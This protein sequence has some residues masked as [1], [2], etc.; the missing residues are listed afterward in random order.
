MAK[1]LPLNA[2]VALSGK[3]RCKM[4]PLRCYT[5]G[6]HWSY[7]TSTAFLPTDFR[8]KDDI[9]GRVELILIRVQ[10]LKIVAE[11]I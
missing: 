4:I 10:V 5:E 8:I 7:L 9:Q 6:S 11:G 1:A 3:R 2:L